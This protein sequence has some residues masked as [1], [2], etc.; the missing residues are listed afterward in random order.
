VRRIGI[1]GAFLIGH[2]QIKARLVEAFAQLFV[3]AELFLKPFL[4]A[5]EVLRGLGPIPK[6]GLSRFFKEFFLARG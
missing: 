2:R 1:V 5:E 3:A 6:A 4:F